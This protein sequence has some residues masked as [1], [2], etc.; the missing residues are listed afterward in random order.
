[1]NIKAIAERVT[2]R[3]YV[4][5]ILALIIIFLGSLYLKTFYSEGAYFEDA[6]LKKE[7]RLSETYY[8]GRHEEG[9]IHIVISALKDT[10]DSV[11][12]RYSLPNNIDRDYTVR[13]KDA[14]NWD[15]GIENIIYNGNIIFQGEYVEGDLFLWDENVNPMLGDN[16]RITFHDQATFDKSYKISKLS[17]AKFASYHNDTI[18]GKYEHLVMAALLALI[19]IIDV[20]YP[21]LFFRLRHSLSV[22]NPEPSD[23]Y[24]TTQRIAWFVYPIIIVGLLLA[25]I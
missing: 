2:K 10:R 4:I 14:N 9:E 1:M 6:F 8:I 17:I 7:V 21:K 23:F 16:F 24:I 18:R 15:K 3:G 13:F 11:N 22:N 19:L 5:L 12:V 25:A 20:K